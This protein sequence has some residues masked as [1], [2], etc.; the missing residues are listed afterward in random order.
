MFGGIDN[1]RATGLYFPIEIGPDIGGSAA[2]ANTGTSGATIGLLNAANTYSAV[3]TFNSG[4]LAATA[5]AFTGT[6]TGT[7]TL[8]GT[9]TIPTSGLNGTLQAAQEPAHTGDMTNTAGSLATTVTK[10]NGVDQTTGLTAYTPTVTSGSGTPTTVSA[11]GRWK[12]LPNKL[13][14]VTMTITITTVGT[15]AGVVLAT[16]PTASSSSANY[17]G[18]CYEHNTTGNT[19][20]AAVIGGLNTGR[21]QSA[22]Y[23]GATFWVNG[24]AVDCT[25]TY[26]TP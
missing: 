3:Q 7:Y 19:G 20:A 24:Y 2:F 10:I 4:M 5:P 8:G 14:Y 1:L 21:L 18:V 25:V 26:E 12:Q 15:A 11:T 22:H 17:I 13:A 6:I 23:G 9:P 16:L